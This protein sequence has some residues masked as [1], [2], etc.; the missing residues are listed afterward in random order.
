MGGK[1]E[2]EVEC[3][4]ASR[5]QEEEVTEAGDRGVVGRE[6]AGRGW[7]SC[8]PREWDGGYLEGPCGVGR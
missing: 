7:V 2:M 3:E 6:V 4:G 8:R 1:G 5:C